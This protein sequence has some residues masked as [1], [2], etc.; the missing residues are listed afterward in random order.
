MYQKHLPLVS[1]TMWPIWPRHMYT[2]YVSCNLYSPGVTGNAKVC[3]QM[4]TDLKHF[5]SLIIQTRGIKMDQRLRVNFS[6][7]NNKGRQYDQSF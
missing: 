3:R 1:V 5:F 4:Q 7:G 2:K 6:A